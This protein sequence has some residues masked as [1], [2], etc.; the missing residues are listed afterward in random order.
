MF[1]GTGQG[2]A[3]ANTDEKG[4]VDSECN[5]RYEHNF[6]LCSKLRHAC[7]ELICDDMYLYN[8]RV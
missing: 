5:I 6:R 3:I 4:R 7:L 1:G 8:I 2:Y